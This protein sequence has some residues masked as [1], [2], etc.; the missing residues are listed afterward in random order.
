[1]ASLE[2]RDW[3]TG[4]IKLDEF[5]YNE[6]KEENIAILQAR[7]LWGIVYGRVPQ[8]TDADKLEEWHEKQEQA[9]GVIKLN[10]GLVKRSLIGK[11]PTGT[12]AWEILSEKSQLKDPALQGPLRSKFHA[13]KRG[14]SHRVRIP[15]DGDGQ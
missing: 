9:L 4:T 5:N 11:A 13:L 8:P 2:S 3:V 6:W 10:C 15:S 14:N 7:K 12:A 1:M